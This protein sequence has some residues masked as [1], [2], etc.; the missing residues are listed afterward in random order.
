ML[1]GL[2][3]S[4]ASMTVSAPVSVLVST[5][6]LTVPFTGRVTT[7]SGVGVPELFINVQ[8]VDGTASAS[9][10]TDSNGNFN[11]DIPTG[12]DKFQ[13]FWVSWTGSVTYSTQ[14]SIPDSWYYTV[15]SFDVTNALN[16]NLQLPAT[17]SLTVT[18]PN[19]S[20]IHI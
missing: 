2:N 16:W 18:V 7:Q 8:R 15:N 6:G 17:T 10:R 3:P 20:L 12:L 13:I 9:G 19:L 1:Q 5:S 14:L 4:S 11:I